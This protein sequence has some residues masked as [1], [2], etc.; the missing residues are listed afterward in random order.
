MRNNSIDTVLEV[1]LRHEPGTLAQVA[2]APLDTELHEAITDAVT[3]SVVDAGATN[4]AK[5]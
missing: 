5:P 1:H 2:V 3:R 4:S